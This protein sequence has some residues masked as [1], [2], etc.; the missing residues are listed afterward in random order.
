MKIIHCA[1]LHLDSGLQTHLSREKAKLRR[2]ELLR[3]FGRLADY[4]DE[5]DVEVILIAGDLF[6]RDTVSELTGNMVL[7]VI[8]AHPGIRFYYLRG[9]HDTGDC[10]GRHAQD[11]L[12]GNLFF[13]GSG[14]KTYAEGKNGGISIAGI[15]L[16]R[17]NSASAHASLRLDPESFNIV[18]LHGQIESGVDTVPEE[19]AD[20]AGVRGYTANAGRNGN[21]GSISLRALRGKGI[22]YLAL[23][24]IHSWKRERLDGRGIYCYPGCL[25]GRGFDESGG[26]GFA[27]LEIEEGKH[28]L[29]QQFVPFAQRTLHALDVDVTGCRTTAQMT[30]RI[31]ERV[32]QEG[33]TA[34]DMADVTL[35][36]DLDVDCEK[37][38]GYMESVLAG[39]FF[40]AKLRDRTSLQICLEDYLYDESLRGEFVRSVLADASIPEEEKNEVIR[41]GFKAM[42]GEEVL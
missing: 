12:P 4:A 9:N 6:D 26:H 30:E 39:W 33:C 41:L 40:F 24:H 7:A 34:K 18:M 10:L 11:A 22:D 37:D 25:E 28:V 31:R 42:D 16:T 19:T 38:T 2:D 14:W 13:F 20:S 5:H 8:A 27:L 29:R 23:G 15:E 36:G 32:S 1:D 3:N 21:A 17:K 35:R